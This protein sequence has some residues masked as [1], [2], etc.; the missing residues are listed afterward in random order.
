MYGMVT[1][2]VL[3]PKHAL[4]RVSSAPHIFSRQSSRAEAYTPREG[5]RPHP[6][7]QHYGAVL[8]ERGSSHGPV[9]PVESRLPAAQTMELRRSRS[10]LPTSK[11]TV[12]AY[13]KPGAKGGAAGREDEE[14][15]DEEKWAGGAEAGNGDADESTPMLGFLSAEPSNDFLPIL[16]TV[17]SCL[18]SLLFGFH[19]GFSSPF[20][21]AVLQTE[22]LGKQQ[23]DLMFSLI[24]IGAV[25]GALTSGPFS[26]S[27]GR[28]TGIVFS[29]VPYVIGSLLMVWAHHDLVFLCLG[30]L[31]IGVGVGSSSVLV[32]L[33][34]A[35][36]APPARRGTLGTAS[37][38]F[39]AGGL[40][41]VNAAGIPAVRQP[42]LWK[43]VLLSALIPTGVMAVVMQLWGCE[44]PRFLM[45]VQRTD[46]A[47]RALR[48][49]RGAH[50]DVEGE[51]NEMMDTEEVGLGSVAHSKEALRA[52]KEQYMKYFQ[53]EAEQVVDYGD[54]QDDLSSY[55]ADQQQQQQ[56]GEPQQDDDVHSV[57][58]Q[59]AEVQQAQSQQLVTSASATS[60]P[61]IAQSPTLKSSLSKP[62]R[63]SSAN[64]PPHTTTASSASS[65]VSS[66]LPASNS[67]TLPEAPRD[68]KSVRVTLPGRL[69]P[70][71]LSSLSGA[72]ASP[73]DGSSSQPAKLADKSINMLARARSMARRAFPSSTVLPSSSA[74]AE[75][76]KSTWSVYTQRSHLVPLLLGVSLQVLQQWSGINAFMFHLKATLQDKA[77]QSGDGKATGEASSGDAADSEIRALYGAVAVAA[78]QMVMGGFAMVLMEKAGRRVWLLLSSLGMSASALLLA[79]SSFAG[80][81][82]NINILLVMTYIASFAIGMGPMPWLVCSE[83]FPSAI[84]SSAVS[85]A[86]TANWLN[87]FAVTASYPVL[88]AWL[89]EANV[90]LLYSAVI[91]LGILYVFFCLPETAGKSLDEIEDMFEVGG[92]GDRGAG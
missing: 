71:P 23:L 61:T 14:G 31:L 38:F 37:S 60:L 51:I 67:F 45:S 70:E 11:A 35:E 29:S 42:E 88:E 49:L 63:A 73:S 47:K 48:R 27:F 10:E 78:L 20:E 85:I 36:I 9:V 5:V 87:A 81:P 86:T 92:D 44:T 79:Y 90:Y 40:V 18:G 1:K 55:Q 72:S 75:G 66:D 62:K 57:Q 33:Y 50:W 77:P 53:P 7:D 3:K 46:A 15:R 8:T 84:R 82:N 83:I 76:E 16:L 56:A 19:I 13:S 22:R 28:R 6:P 89:G 32:P 26:A 25:I 69:D 64:S 91:G 17:V 12:F 59:S 4:I 30:R 65:T 21:D 58:V 80:A 74:P 52:W 39:M 43:L 54:L 34:V 24:S 2:Y 41:I 68:K